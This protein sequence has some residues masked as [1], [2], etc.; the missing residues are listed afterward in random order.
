MKIHNCAWP[1][2]DSEFPIPTF[3]WRDVK[4]ELP[5]KQKALICYVRLDYVLDNKKY[6]TDYVAQGFYTNDY[7]TGI[8]KWYD[9]AGDEIEGTVLAWTPFEK[10]SFIKE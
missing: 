3:H 8:L 4:K 10:P 7:D 1:V 6:D 9:W 5:K 2:C